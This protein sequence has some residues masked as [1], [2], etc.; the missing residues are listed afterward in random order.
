MNQQQLLDLISTDA[1]MM[2]VLRL[3]RELRLPDSW[4]GAGF[5]RGKVWDE[6][7]GYRERTPLTDV[8]VIYYDIDYPEESFEQ[9][10]ETKLRAQGPEV[11]WSVT[12]Q[13][14]MH[15]VNGEH[16]Y[17]NTAD[18]IARWPETCTAVAVRLTSEH[19]LELLAPWGIDDLVNMRVRP[20]PMFE[21]KMDEFRAR[22]SKK[23]WSKNGQR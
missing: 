20:T 13:A 15:V 11:N 18:A 23:Q 14:R 2:E 9:E 7:S 12:N 8:D 21:K 22:Q 19:T 5:V 17:L 10:A 4:V 1:W 3:V 16:P 6:L